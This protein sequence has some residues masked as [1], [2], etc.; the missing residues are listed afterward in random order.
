M[1]ITLEE[2]EIQYR[3]IYEA[4]FGTPRIPVYEIASLL[5]VSRNA[6]S[7]R[8]NEAFYLG[9]LSKPQIRRRSYAN[10]IEYLYFL[11]CKNPVELF[12]KCRQTNSIIYHATLIG[13]TNLWVV[14]REKLDFDCDV[15]IE[16]PR[17]D[18]HISYAPHHSWETAIQRMRKKV[19]TFN[20]REY[21]PEG[22][23]KTHWNEQIE[24][25]AEH[26]KLFNEFNYDLRRSISPILKKNLISW[27]KV[28]AWLRNLPQYCTVFTCYYPEKISTYD[29]YLFVFETDYEDFLVNLFS[30]L[31]TT[32]WFF[33][34]SNRLFVLTHIKKEFLRVV[35]FQVDIGQLQIPTLV[36]E[37]HSKRIIRSEVS[38]LVQCYW[39]TDP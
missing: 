9:Y 27:G 28:E 25:D 33:T 21:A 17:S 2:K 24:W 20:P 14:S 15:L 26:E 18:Y 12:S 39:N 35:D 11:R 31:P 5:Q 29:P 23:I 10:M 7:N 37:L 13:S 8:M 3:A 34:V 4:L 6:A 16:G 22:I 19:E 32:A 1:R 38:A 30:E 36:A